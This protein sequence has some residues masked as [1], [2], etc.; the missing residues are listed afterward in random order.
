[1][2]EEMAEKQ[3][4]IA[5]QSASEPLSA[6]PRILVVEDD[7]ISRNLLVAML[8]KLG[9]HV[10]SVGNGAEALPALQRSDYWAV[11]M[12]CAMPKMDGYEAT[13]QIRSAHSA[14][15]NPQIIVIAV[16]A[17]GS[18]GHRE[19]CLRAGMNDYLL[20]PVLR[21]DLAAILAKWGVA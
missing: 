10:D 4:T 9:F 1:M 8:T 6:P 19:Q 21:K 2:T 12:D 3:G 14:V 13:Q 18:P 17:N 7:W 5:T 16:T 11:L 20:K 15:R